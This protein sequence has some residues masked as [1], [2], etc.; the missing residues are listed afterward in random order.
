[1]LDAFLSIMKK[2][3]G[4]SWEPE[5][6]RPKEVVMISDFDLPLSLLPP[7]PTIAE[8]ELL[9]LRVS[10]LPGQRPGEP[11]SVL[12]LRFFLF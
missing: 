4:V 6:E 5:G 8:V 2:D 7:R 1:M 11:H 12:H 3:K 9:V 10:P